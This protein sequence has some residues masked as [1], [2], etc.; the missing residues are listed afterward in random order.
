[1]I[2]IYVGIE[3]YQKYDHCTCFWCTIYMLPYTNLTWLM[4]V[5]GTLN[6]IYLQNKEQ[7]NFIC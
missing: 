1:M 5:I 6:K 4:I 3:Q 7:N 2:K